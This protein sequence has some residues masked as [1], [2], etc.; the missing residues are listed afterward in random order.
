MSGRFFVT[1]GAVE[2]W[3]S[4]QHVIAP[5]GS[6][7]WKLGERELTELVNL[8]AERKQPKPDG[9]QLVYKVGRELVREVT[10]P[11]HPFASQKQ[12]AVAGRLEI[13]LHVTRDSQLVAVRTRSRASRPQ[14]SR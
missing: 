2:G 13:Y 1:D 3:L 5:K 8:A 11:D 6:E 10:G 12:G 14:G 7:A 4:G 9:V